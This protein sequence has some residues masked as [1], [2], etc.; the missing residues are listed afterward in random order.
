[1]PNLRDDHWTAPVAGAS[2]DAA[3]RVPGSKSITNRAYVLAALAS[4]P[5]R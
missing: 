5:T 3:V 4:A 1:M 2:L